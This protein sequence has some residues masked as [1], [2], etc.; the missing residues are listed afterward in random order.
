MSIDITSRWK[1]KDKY[2]CSKSTLYLDV[3]LYNIITENPLRT[4]QLMIIWIEC[5]TLYCTFKILLIIDDNSFS[6][7]PLVLKRR[8][9]DITSRWKQKDKYQCSKS[10]LYLDVCCIHL[11]AWR[12]TNLYSEPVWGQIRVNI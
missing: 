10:T 12:H 8:T 2:Q 11:F 4:S 3:I 1:Q 9:I 6:S 7:C 5:H